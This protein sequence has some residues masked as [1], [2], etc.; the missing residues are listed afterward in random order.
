LIPTVLSSEI[1]ISLQEERIEMRFCLR[2]TIAGLALTLALAGCGGGGGGGSAATPPPASAPFAS[3]NF[4]GRAAATNPPV[5][6]A[7]QATVATGLTGVISQLKL[8]Q[9][10]VSLQD[11]RIAFASGI[12]GGGDVYTCNIDGSDQFHLTKT[13][14]IGE[15]LPVISPGGNKVAVQFFDSTLLRHIDLYRS[16]A[17]F[18][19]HVTT[20]A[21]QEQHPTWSPD[22]SKLMYEQNFN[23]P[24]HLVQYTLS[25]GATT[26]I[27][28]GGDAYQPSWSSLN[29][30]AFVS[31][32][33]GGSEVFE[34]NA[35]GTSPAQITSGD[36][37]DSPAWSTDGETLYWV[38]HTATPN[39]Q[40]VARHQY[41]WGWNQQSIYTT[42]DN[43]SNLAP[44]P[45]GTLV[46]FLDA[47]TNTIL[48][49]PSAGGGGASALFPSVGAMFGFSWGPLITDRLMV[50]SGGLLSAT[51]SGFIYADL[52]AR[53]QSVLSFTAT[54]PSSVV[55]KALTGIGGTEQSL[56]FSV[57]ADNLS[58]IGYGDGP[59]WLL[60]PVV[61]GGTS[62]PSANGALISINAF[63]GKVDAV[64]PYNGTR[65]ID[66]KR[67]VTRQGDSYVFTGQFLS[68]VD[69][70]GKNQA[71]NGASK[72]VL[73]PKTGTLTAS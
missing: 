39:N 6:T 63:T 4:T 41:F 60:V 25:G 10:A 43:I 42:T 36:P 30:L 21:F 64:L 14:T 31:S 37:N 66:S 19:A 24:N 8:R 13:T 11:T 56:L 49:V 23:G 45:D 16:D 1:D 17:V 54:T 48:S 44:S 70:S 2:F 50:G 62:T 38:D 61:Q 5:T 22:S 68:A 7:A 15:E 18:L 34:S 26:T 72:V 40:I 69:G 59:A 71:P 57:D 32:R 65:A 28:T 51:S 3:G 27:D 53:T 67:T 47:S 12:T 46:A 33:T 52:G 20:G 29:K 9:Q 58:F 73:D 55:L 35:D